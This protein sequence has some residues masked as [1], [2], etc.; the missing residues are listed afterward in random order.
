ML[1]LAMICEPFIRLVLSPSAMVF[2]KH[3]HRHTCLIRQHIQVSA[4]HLH[5]IPLFAPLPDYTAIAVPS[6]R[7]CL[8]LSTRLPSVG[9]GPNYTRLMLETIEDV[10]AL[11]E[12]ELMRL[13]KLNQVL[14]PPREQLVVQPEHAWN[15]AESEHQYSPAQMRGIFD[16]LTPPPLGQ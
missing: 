9:T 8:S 10:D 1:P 2:S 15:S 4:R 14:T 11:D 13:I 6:C 16:F 5:V 7:V 12:L 3:T